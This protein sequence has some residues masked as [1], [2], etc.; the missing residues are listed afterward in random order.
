VLVQD[1]EIQLPG[2]PI[3]VGPGT[4]RGALLRPA[5]D[6]ALAVIFHGT[7]VQI[8]RLCSLARKNS[9]STLID[10]INLVDLVYWKNQ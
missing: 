4:Y 2:P 8:V 6:R 9:A 7:S 10:P 1:L 3:L 5:R